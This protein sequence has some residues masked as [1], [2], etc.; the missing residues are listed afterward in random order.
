MGAHWQKLGFRSA[1]D[2]GLM[3]RASAQGQLTIVARFL[4]LS[5]LAERLVSG[6]AT[7]FARLYNGPR[8]AEN[9]YHTKIA[10]AYRTAR[11][12]LGEGAA[13]PA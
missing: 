5:H 13:A 10:A 3:A 9:A 11:R 7:G 8:Y 12:A 6:D 4:K 1:A 2:L